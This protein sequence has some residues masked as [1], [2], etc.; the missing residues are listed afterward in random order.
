MGTIAAGLSAF[1]PLLAPQEPAPAAP[2]AAPAEI[3]L[4]AELDPVPL[5]AFGL[6]PGGVE[7]AAAGRRPAALCWTETGC[8]TP[9]GV[10]IECLGAG[11]KLTFPS[12]RELLIA[13]DGFLHL[14]GGGVAG[15]FAAGLEL[16]LGDGAAVRVQLSQAQRHRLRSV[17]VAHGDRAIEL[18]RRGRRVQQHARVGFWGGVRLCC[19]GD[20]GDLYRAIALGPLITLERVLVPGG[21]ESATPATRLV[22]LTRP[23]LAALAELPRQHRTPDPDLRAAI[24]AVGLVA[25]RADMILPPGAELQRAEPDQLR[26]V[27]RGG[28]ELELALEGDRAPRLSLFA[29]QSLRPM[30]EWAIAGNPA[31]FLNNPH[32]SDPGASRWRG[33]GVPLVF[34]VPEFQVRDALFEQP[35]ALGAIRALVER[36]PVVGRARPSPGR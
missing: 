2:V 3:V 23:M 1:L 28:Y 16:R 5:S 21:R 29:G 15:P 36:R 22:V 13:P 18:W 10:Q 14:R 19:C 12:E 17:E 7:P 11:V 35:R 32:A 20:G 33:N 4:A 6:G 9:G 25:D 30:V 27:L 8:T 26:W 31:A 24:A 34:T